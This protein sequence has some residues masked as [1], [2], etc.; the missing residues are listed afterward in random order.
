M[1]T[2]LIIKNSTVAGKV[3][4]EGDLSRGELGLN[5]TDKK[6]YTK[7]ANDDIVQIG[8]SVEVSDTAPTG[9]TVTSGSLWFNST[10]GEGGGRLYIYY[11]DDDSAQWIDASPDMQM[12]EYW[13]RDGND[14]KPVKQNDN[15][16]V[17]VDAVTLSSSGTGAFTGKVSSAS[18][19]SG[20]P[21]TTLV[22]KDFLGSSGAP[23]PT[24][25]Q[26]TSAGNTTANTIY[27]DGGLEAGS[28]VKVEGSVSGIESTINNGTFSTT[29][30][31]GNT[32]DLYV[33]IKGGDVV[34]DVN[35]DGSATFAGDIK[36]G[37]LTYNQPAG[38]GVFLQSGAS[39]YDGFIQINNHE[40]A[41]GTCF[42]IRSNTGG[43]GQTSGLVTY[44]GNDGKITTAGDVRIGGTLPSAPNI[45]LKADG[46]ADIGGR[47]VANGRSAISDNSGQT[48]ASYDK[49]GNST[50]T[51]YVTAGGKLVTGLDPQGNQIN[52]GASL[53]ST[54]RID[55]KGNALDDVIFAGSGFGSDNLTTFITAGGSITAAGNVQVGD[56][57]P[58]AGSYGV[59]LYPSGNVHVSR[60]A[61]STNPV[62]Q[63]TDENAKYT[64]QIFSDGSI[65]AAGIVDVGDASGTT[66]YVRSRP[67]GQVYIRPADT[68]GDS[69]T[70]FQVFSG[71]NASSDA[72]VTVTKDGRITASKTITGT[73]QSG[74]GTAVYGLGGS[75]AGTS[76]VFAGRNQ[77][78]T[79]T[80]DVRDNG[81]ATF[82]GSV[83][84]GG[85]DAA[86]T[87]DEYEEGTWSPS[88]GGDATY[89]TQTGSYTKIGRAVIV[90]FE[91]VVSTLGTGSNAAI[92]NLPF[93][94][95]GPTGERA[96][97]ISYF[98]NINSAVGSM[99]CYAASNTNRVYFNAV[100]SGGDTMMSNVNKTIFQDGTRVAGAVTYFTA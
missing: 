98:E 26:V 14:L 54:G 20:D 46:T 24:L 69:S 6:L 64:T 30:K 79:L 40:A 96:G 97:V 68:A 50:P 8:D 5:L 16:V 80:F 62:F 48:I 65:T 17:G 72:T 93:N 10:D 99:V 81:N 57:A 27:T 53:R 71:G 44:M 78:G 89:T 73:A 13:T 1:S 70:A 95:A 56:N 7:D 67:E 12:S 33:G 32:Q 35:Y 49:D 77:S 2:T 90:K 58:A 85:N 66:G 84:I 36:T 92:E 76:S 25:Q 11:Q 52:I 39:G 42:Q 18:T 23:V 87:I 82:N 31:D 37:D 3:P 63:A 21:G 28:Y 94:V 60:E 19:A 45:D 22:T 43:S 75:D 9:S 29:I 86:H 38:G 61:S 15:V 51:F 41:G 4:S 55:V 59:K 34:F 91:I 74:T 88:V 47:V 100:K 83:A